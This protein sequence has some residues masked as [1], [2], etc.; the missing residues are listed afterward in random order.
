MDIEELRRRRRALLRHEQR[1]V[2]YEHVPQPILTKIAR[3]TRD[4]FMNGRWAQL[5]RQQREAPPRDRVSDEI[6]AWMSPL[7]PDNTCSGLNGRLCC[8][9]EGHRRAPYASLLEFQR[10][11]V[12]KEPGA[13]GCAACLESVAG[14]QDV[15]PTGYQNVLS[16]SILSICPLCGC[17]VLD[18]DDSLSA[19][20]S[21]AF[22]SDAYVAHNTCQLDACRSVDKL[23]QSAGLLFEWFDEFVN[24]LIN[25]IV[26]R[27]R[28][29][30]Y[31]Q[32][33]EVLQREALFGGHRSFDVDAS[34]LE[35]YKLVTRT[36]DTDGEVQFEAT[37][38]LTA[39]CVAF[40]AARTAMN[41]T[42]SLFDL[43]DVAY[44]AKKVQRIQP[45]GRGNVIS[46]ALL[47][48]PRPP[49][50]E[51]AS[52]NIFL[53][54][55]FFCRKGSL[56]SATI[57]PLKHHRSF[58]LPQMS[59]LVFETNV[60]L[61][62]TVNLGT[63]VAWV[64]SHPL[65]FGANVASIIAM[66]NMLE[67]P[68]RVNFVFKDLA[69]HAVVGLARRPP[70]P[71]IVNAARLL[72]CLQLRRRPSPIITRFMSSVNELPHPIACA[73]LCKPLPYSAQGYESGGDDDELVF[74]DDALLQETRKVYTCSADSEPVLLAG[75][76][77]RAP[78]DEER[79]AEIQT[80]Y[81]AKFVRR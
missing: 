29:Q 39:S 17:P 13:L 32:E 36:T 42:P 47:P 5:S 63:T 15:R 58:D 38:A 76:E 37:D 62:A 57:Q 22:G 67:D 19:T 46:G 7:I 72:A 74:R 3:G 23:C 71:V 26:D 31:E 54:P 14:E 30:G 73:V 68:S 48:T 43:N 6:A 21:P 55:D 28:R 24:S 25:Q 51:D 77:K 70:E 41:A 2:M 20:R 16:Q 44:L 81:P 1:Q 10:S 79:L 18:A 35:A 8:G 33:P 53:I 12:P 34:A 75:G 69:P 80:Y 60:V 11:R 9:V 50:G 64:V 49:R 27:T 4:V 61:S 66:I 40:M 78:I 52:N 59:E 56:T 65:V 45:P